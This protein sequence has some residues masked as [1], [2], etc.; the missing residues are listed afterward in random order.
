[1]KNSKKALMIENGYWPKAKRPK[2][3]TINT[4]KSAT[5]GSKTR[6]KVD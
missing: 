6:R 4:L 1:M 3:R 5:K 2:H